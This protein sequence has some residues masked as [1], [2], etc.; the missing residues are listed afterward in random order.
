MRAPTTPDLCHTYATTF[1]TYATTLQAYATPMPPPSRPI[2]VSSICQRGR[3]V[4]LF[5]I[6][7]NV[8]TMCPHARPFVGVFQKSILD[9]FV[10]F[11]RFFPSKWLQ[12]R[13]Q[14]PKPSPGIPPR[15]A[16]CG[17][18]FPR[19]GVGHGERLVIY[20]QTTGVS[21]AR[22]THCATYCTPCRPLIRAF[23]GWIR[24]PPPTGPRRTPTPNPEPV[25][26]NP[27]S[28][29]TA[30]PRAANILY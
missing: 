14:N 22:A 21:A 30:G 23:S 13:P 20:C 10:I 24:T 15:R 19:S 29:C 6:G 18:G 2:R 26:L 7:T 17:C 8:A 9:R 28:T 16:C 4:R 5:R 1:P 12:N 11:W 27:S 3:N 25:F